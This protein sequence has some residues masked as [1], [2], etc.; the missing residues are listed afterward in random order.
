[1][2]ITSIGAE[3]GGIRKINTSTMS[4]TPEITPKPIPP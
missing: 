4:P 3:A 2:S 1:M